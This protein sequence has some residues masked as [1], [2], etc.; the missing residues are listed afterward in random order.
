M[1]KGNGVK[2]IYAFKGNQ[3]PQDPYTGLYVI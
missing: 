1:T 2:A 3:H